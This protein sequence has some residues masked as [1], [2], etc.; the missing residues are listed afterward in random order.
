MAGKLYDGNNVVVGN[1]V[2]FTKPWSLTTPAVLLPDDTALWAIAPW[3][4]AGWQSAGATNEGFKINAEASTTTVT[5][6][7]QS[8]PVGES[9]EGKSIGI[10]AALAEDTLDSIKA[11]WGGGT[12][13]TQAPSATLVGTAKMSLVNN[14]QYVAAVL[15]MANFRGLPRRIFIPKMSLFGAGETSFRRASDKRLYPIRLNSLCRPDEIQIVD[16]TAPKS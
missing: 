11:A 12:I 1:A 10:E 13:V 9:L 5:V 2:L 16:V 4:A 7:E 14:I 6:E 8:T 3:E 15:E